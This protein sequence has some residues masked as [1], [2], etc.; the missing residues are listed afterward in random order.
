MNAITFA[1]D[2]GKEPEYR[3][4][5]RIAQKNGVKILSRF[6]HNFHSKI[7]RQIPRIREK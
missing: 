7:V 6:G 3:R 5:P 4:F 2:M 1:K